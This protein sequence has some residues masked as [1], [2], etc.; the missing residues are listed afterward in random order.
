MKFKKIIPYK[1]KHVLPILGL[2][3]ASVVSSCEKVAPTE[4]KPVKTEME[5]IFD[6]STFMDIL[7]QTDSLG[8][9]VVSDIVNYYVEN[10]DIKTVYL[11]SIGD[12]SSEDSSSIN[13]MVRYRMRPLFETSSKLRGRGDFNFKLGEA[14]KVPEDSLWF[15]R[16]GYTI[17][18]QY[19]R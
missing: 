9:T 1:M 8:Y 17:N 18:K 6:P 12:W 11:H 2:A 7:F 14:S 4:P 3:G 19:Q 16:N 10:P 15:V 5:V 13:L